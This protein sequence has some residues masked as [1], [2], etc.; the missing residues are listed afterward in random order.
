MLVAGHHWVAHVFK[1]ET[2]A[3]KVQLHSA[4][5]DTH[6]DDGNRRMKFLCNS[7]VLLFQQVLGSLGRAQL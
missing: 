7:N 6:Q 3:A 1:A 4:H 5:R 2:A